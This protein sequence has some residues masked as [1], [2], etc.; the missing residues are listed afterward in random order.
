LSLRWRETAELFRLMVEVPATGEHKG[1][2]L[3]RHRS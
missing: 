1:R 3:A 2:V